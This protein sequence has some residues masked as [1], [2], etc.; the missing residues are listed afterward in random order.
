M[1][2]RVALVRKDVS[3]KLSASIIRMTGIGKLGTTLAVTSNRRKL[4]RNTK[5]LIMEALS[6]SETSAITRVT[7]CNVP[8][9]RIL[10]SHCRQNLKYYIELT[11]WAL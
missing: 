3:E 5:T 8:E 4:R 6:S 9:D 2:R 1:L 10:H 7:R 11:D